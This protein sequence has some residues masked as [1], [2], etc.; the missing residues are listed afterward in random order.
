MDMAIPD[1]NHKVCIMCDH[2]TEDDCP[3]FG[4]CEYVAD[5]LES[6][7]KKQNND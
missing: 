7:L 3:Y 6:E 5:Y 1:I 4:E 2:Y